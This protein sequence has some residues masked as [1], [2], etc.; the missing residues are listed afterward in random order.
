MFEQ[1]S[2]MEFS[3]GTGQYPQKILATVRA[4]RESTDYTDPFVLQITCHPDDL[5]NVMSSIP[6][7]IDGKGDFHIETLLDPHADPD[8][9]VLVCLP[10][11][12]GSSEVAPAESRDR[13]EKRAPTTR[14]GAA[15]PKAKTKKR[16]GSPAAKTKK[17][18]PPEKK[19]RR[20]NPPS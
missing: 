8:D 7:R 3:Q 12:P 18:R 5:E 19:A 13:E 17:Q 11:G 15:A 14:R 2:S 20:R 6:F 16:R 1:E 10:G 4:F 9:L